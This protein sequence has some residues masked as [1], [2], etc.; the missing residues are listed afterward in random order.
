MK[1]GSP[2]Q[3]TFFRATG[4]PVEL[5]GT[6]EVK[7]QL[8]DV[9]AVKAIFE[10][11]LVRRPILS[12][13]RLV[14][15]GFA[16]VMGNELENKMSKCKNGREIHLHKSSGV[17]LVRASALSELYPLEDQE[18]RNDAGPSARAVGEAAAPWT[19]RHSYKPTDEERMAPLVSH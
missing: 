10:L 4:A 16:V 15:K 3:G 13:S 7:F 2:Q 12:V 18:P 14:P 17:Y 11:L 5:Q 9:P 1:S 8:V 6:T 19:S